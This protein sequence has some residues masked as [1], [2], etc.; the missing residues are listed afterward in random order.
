MAIPTK[1][2]MQLYIL[3]HLKDGQ[4]HSISEVA[5]H[6][7]EVLNIDQNE[8]KEI[9]PV[10]GRSKFDIRVRWA[11][12]TLRKAGL[13]ENT[14]LGR[15]KITDGGIQILEKQPTL[16]NDA[17]LKKYCSKYVEWI[18]SYRRTKEKLQNKAEH[19]QETSGI[20]SII[21]ILGT[22]GS[23]KGSK[24]TNIH[25]NWNKLIHNTRSL[26]GSENSFEDKSTLVTFSDTMFITVK[27]KNADD[28]LCAFSKTIWSVI[29]ESIR[30]D[31]PIRGCVSCGKFF[32][33]N[34]FF[35]G[36]AVDEAA[37]YYQLPQWIGISAAPSAH[38]VINNM[39]TK[40]TDLANQ[41]FARHDIP[42]KNSIEQDAWVVNWPRQCDEHEDVADDDVLS[43]IEQTIDRKLGS[44]TDIDAA[45]K[46]RNTRKFCSHVHNKMYERA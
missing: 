1:D 9:A 12:H 7:V 46:W 16:I 15:F 27:G 43:S 36:K 28:L 34:N 13:L 45:L 10:S 25:K 31:M 11:V 30:M 17:F 35:T 19:P 38:S 2:V 6:V 26:L 24:P 40:S 29:V 39:I 42:L 37:Q 8:R 44:L 18:T 33:Q 3:E 32:L 4:L 21:D 23:W 14:E 5:D 41:Y 22:K 20:V